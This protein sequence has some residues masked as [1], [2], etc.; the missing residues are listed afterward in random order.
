MSKLEQG[1]TQLSQAPEALKLFFQRA[2]E[3]FDASVAFRLPDER[4]RGLD[5]QE[6]ELALEV[7][8]HVDAAVVVV[9][10][11]ASSDAGLKTAK[12]LVR[13]L[14]IGSSASKRV[15]FF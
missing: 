5:P 11:E 1:S 12:V 3:A 15:A 4:G 13:S 7:V 9:Q 10:P 2:E 6:L 8:A 14:R